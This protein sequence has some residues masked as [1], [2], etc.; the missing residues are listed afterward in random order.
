M[1][2]GHQSSDIASERTLGYEKESIGNST[3]RNK[4]IL[5]I[6]ESNPD[7]PDQRAFLHDL[8]CNKPDEIDTIQVE[9]EAKIKQLPTMVVE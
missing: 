5:M 4:F 3:R 7:S 8:I 1:A 9:T 2:D 6:N